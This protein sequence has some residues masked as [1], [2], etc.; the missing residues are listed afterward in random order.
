MTSIRPH[1]ITSVNQEIMYLRDESS[2]HEPMHSSN[3][4]SFCDSIGRKVD[5]V[6]ISVTDRCNLRCV[7]CMGK[8]GI[9]PGQKLKHQSILSLEG[10][11]AFARI[12]AAHGV[13]SIRLTGGEPLTRK[14]IVDLVAALAAIDDID[15]ISM[16]TN[17]QLF[18]AFAAD[19]KKAGLNRI[20]FSLDSTDVQ[21]Y[22]KLTRCGDLDKTL[23][24]IDLALDM[25]FDPVKINVVAY[26]LSDADL[27]RFAHMSFERPLHIRFIEYMPVGNIEGGVDHCPVPPHHKT[28]GNILGNPEDINE[29]NSQENAQGNTK[30]DAQENTRDNSK[31]DS[32]D[33]TEGNTQGAQ[34][35]NEILSV[36]EIKVRIEAIGQENGW[37]DLQ[38]L[39][40]DARPTGKG[41][42]QSYRFENSKGSIGIIAA[43]SHCF[44]A[45]CNRLRLTASGMLRTCLFSD[46]E[47]ELRQ[48]LESKDEALA[49]AIIQ[50]ALLAKP[51]AHNY[52]QGTIRG[53]SQ[54][55]G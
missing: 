25:G 24:A 51:R 40:K 44:C 37:G 4:D 28:A 23:E 22:Q 46:T 13:S 12:V 16:T 7:Y 30:G 26:Q 27:N 43:T 29:G 35:S 55:G 11:E 47:Y 2:L 1:A 3:S 5:Y 18:A 19:L 45:S 10:I 38:A 32:Q 48:A 39:G 6:R 17:G 15:D 14:G 49:E 20:T 8:D 21:T 54:I 34:A 36:D 53:M 33:N 41:P 31:D 42:A 50:E 52:N 9:S